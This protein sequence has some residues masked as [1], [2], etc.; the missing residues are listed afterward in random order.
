MMVMT[1]ILAAM[2]WAQILV[3]AIT[4]LL[5]E[6]ERVWFSIWVEHAALV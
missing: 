5:D 2:D 4:W 1:L 6:V 3:E